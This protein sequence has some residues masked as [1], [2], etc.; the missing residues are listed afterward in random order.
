DPC[1][2]LWDDVSGRARAKSAA[3]PVPDGLGEAAGPDPLPLT[4]W[5]RAVRDTLGAL[6]ERTGGDL[7]DAFVE[8]E[9]RSAL[10]QLLVDVL[11]RRP[12][13][14]AVE[15]PA[16]VHVLACPDPRREMEIV[17]AEIRAQL[18]ADPSLRALDIGVWIASNDERYLALAPAVF[19]AVGVPWH[20]I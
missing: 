13:R 15:L 9:P 4:L 18:D 10:E 2:E 20:L 17:A 8:T 1:A 19:E 11:H 12:P 7:H 5:G 14:G 6:V 16:G 3:R